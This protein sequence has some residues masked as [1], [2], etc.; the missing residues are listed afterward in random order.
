[1]LYNMFLLYFNMNKLSK[2]AKKLTNM[3]RKKFANDLKSISNLI[4]IHSKSFEHWDNEVKL[5]LSNDKY[6]I[7]Q[8]VEE[9]EKL[10]D[11]ELTNLNNKK[12]EFDSLVSN[13]IKLDFE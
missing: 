6:R 8:T 2:F 3:S 10:R 1:M 4:E 7:F 11:E 12:A 13:Y 5:K 9:L